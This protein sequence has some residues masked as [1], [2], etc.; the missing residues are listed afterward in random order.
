MAWFGCASA[1]VLS[2]NWT[3]TET[4]NLVIYSDSDPEEVRKLITEMELFR[5][6]ATGIIG[7]RQIVDRKVE[8]VLF[9]RE[10]DMK[11]FAPSRTVFEEYPPQIG[12][13]QDL[14]ALLARIGRQSDVLA[15]LEKKPRKYQRSETG[16]KRVQVFKSGDVSM[17]FR[18]AQSSGSS[19]TPNLTG[20]SDLIPTPV[21]SGRRVRY[22]VT[23]T[24]AL[25]QEASS[26]LV[27]SREQSWAGLRRRIYKGYTQLLMQQT[28]VTSPAWFTEGMSELLGSFVAGQ[29]EYLLGRG[30]EVFSGLLNELDA[31]IPWEDFFAHSLTSSE[32]EHDAYRVA[33]G[34]Q[35]WLLFH[36][37]YFGETRREAWR[38]G[39]LALF[40]EARRGST[41]Y[42][43]MVKRNLGVDIGVLSNELKAYAERSRFVFFKY[44]IPPNFPD[45]LLEQQEVSKTERTKLMEELKIRLSREE[46]YLKK[47]TTSLKPD[48]VSDRR[49]MVGWG[50]WL[51]GDREAALGVWE[52]LEIE[53]YQDSFILRARAQIQIDHW[54]ADPDLEYRFPPEIASQLR[55]QMES[56]L[57]IDPSDQTTMMYLAWLEA[58]SEQ[59]DNENINMVQQSV[60]GM[61]QPELTL[62]AIA[63]IRLRIGD[64]ET[65]RALVYEYHDLEAWRWAELV[66]LMEEATNLWEH[67][68]QGIPSVR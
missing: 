16:I 37:S 10:D 2:A 26:I 63:K 19:N 41:D 45:L 64:L 9:D 17:E 50:L 29:N 1:S 21:M 11:K 7:A 67:V 24:Y 33:F 20:S 53:G 57:E 12:I 30:S 54:L 47:L 5:Q 4:T 28:G 42:L 14:N 13:Y 39:I 52:P 62:L 34:A 8:I 60:G 59:P 46:P 18:S 15:Y 49:Q 3:R 44:P 51:A 25:A 55:H 23:R 38:S 66:N 68:G 32:F 36:Y 6:V 40:S 48:E 22:P 31:F 65:A 58:L 43:G 35:A 61:L 27:L 56:S